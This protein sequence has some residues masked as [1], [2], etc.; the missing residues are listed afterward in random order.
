MEFLHYTYLINQV[1]VKMS[2]GSLAKSAFQETMKIGHLE[3]RIANGC[4]E[5]TW[6]DFQKRV[7]QN[8]LGQG[9]QIPSVTKADQR[10]FCV[11]LQVKSS[12][13]HF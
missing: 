6:K 11:W 1:W 13:L 8:T 4:A 5:A 2:D 9:W 7:F 12:F 3:V 10:L